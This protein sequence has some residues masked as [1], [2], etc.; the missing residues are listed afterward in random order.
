MLI[1]AKKLGRTNLLEY[2][3]ANEISR[4]RPDKRYVPLDTVVIFMSYS[5]LCTS[6]K[7]I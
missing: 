4:S 1:R 2:D 7:R 6:K 3:R 5:I